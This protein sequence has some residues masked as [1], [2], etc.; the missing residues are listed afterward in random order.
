MLI[1]PLL[2]VLCTLFV[3]TLVQATFSFGGALIALPLLAFV[4]SI[5]E[6][7]PLMTI[8]SC[9][10]ALTIIIKNRRDIQVSNAWRL[11]V[12]ACVGIPLGIV[13]LGQV[14]GRI[15]KIVLAATVI[16][17]TIV[18]L[19]SFKALRVSNHNYAFGFGFFSGIFGGAYNISGPPVVLYGTLSDWSPAR[20]RATIQ[21]YAFFTNIFAI[22]GH[23][24]AGNITKDVL[25]YYISA[26]PIVALSIW[27]GNLIHTK[28][29]AEKY[30]LVVKLLLLVLAV[31]LLVS[32]A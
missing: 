25:T 16:V 11:I 10:I 13:F 28:I 9:T 18:N 15:L 7:T 31:R 5:K 26:L 22:G 1:N 24:V 3:S 14:D 30:M 27:L 12:S 20:F 6:A 4:I 21:S 2:G 8:L 23:A 19:F 29:P 32:V 17:F